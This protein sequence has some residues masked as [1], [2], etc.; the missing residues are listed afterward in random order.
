MSACRDCGSKKPS[1]RHAFCAG[2]AKARHVSSVAKWTEKNTEK[3]RTWRRSYY[4]EKKV[5][6]AKR[7]KAWREA[8]SDRERE[9]QRKLAEKNPGRQSAYTRKSK[10][11]IDRK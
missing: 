3:M 1:S 4:R 6:I 9:R 11:G 10:Y 5:H 8:N 2:C 7:T